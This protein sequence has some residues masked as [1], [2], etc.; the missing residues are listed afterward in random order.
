MSDRQARSESGVRRQPRPGAGALLAGRKCLNAVAV[1]TVVLL[2]AH[3]MGAQDR[4]QT[5]NVLALAR[6]AC[7][8]ENGSKSLERTLAEL[9]DIASRD[10]DNTELQ[11]LQERCQEAYNKQKQSEENTFKE[12]QAAF[13]RNSWSEA[14]TKFQFL[15]DRNTPYTADA[16]NYLSIIAKGVTPATANASQDDEALKKADRYFEAEDLNSAQRIYESLAGRGGILGERAKAG[17]E[18][19]ERRRGTL[20]QAKRTLELLSQRRYADAKDLYAQIRQHDPDYRRLDSTMREAERA[21]PR[22]PSTPPPQQPDVRNPRLKREM[23]EAIGT[24]KEGHY[25][26]ALELF[27]NLQFSNPNSAEVRDWMAKAK[28]QIDEQDTAR[29]IEEAQS[30]MRKGQRLQAGKALTR[31]A[32]L[33]PGNARVRELQQQ[34]ERQARDSKER[35]ALAE[36]KTEVRLGRGLQLF[37]GNY[38]EAVREL[39]EYLGLGG[40]RTALAYFFMGAA[41]GSEFYLGGT[42]DSGKEANAREFFLKCRK[43]DPRFRPPRDWVSPKIIKM[44]EEAAGI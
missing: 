2:L 32:N 24:F 36:A 37:D 27:E 3:A 12:A 6:S 5:S 20:I 14:R 4:R 28:K 34:V 33:S 43:A 17:L 44:Y 42:S 21:A 1:L 30:L 25:R 13:Q 8:V 35:A 40:K 38:A 22:A 9:A 7:K 41:S 16:R 11:P 39:Q 10:P 19:I 15:A 23:D 31:A 26:A 29:L 18:R